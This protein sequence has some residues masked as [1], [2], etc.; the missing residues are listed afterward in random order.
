MHAF[1]DEADH[2]RS[3]DEKAKMR[4]L[5]LL[6]SLHYRHHAR[7]RKMLTRSSRILRESKGSKI[8]DMAMFVPN[9]QE[10]NSS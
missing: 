8:L 2:G 10:R 3:L 5:L 1:P 7:Y 9:S 4:H 6:R